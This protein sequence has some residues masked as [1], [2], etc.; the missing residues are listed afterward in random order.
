VQR[1]AR[2]VPQRLTQEVDDYRPTVTIYCAGKQEGELVFRGP[3]TRHW[4]EDLGTRHGHM[5]GIDDRLMEEGMAADYE[6]IAALTGRVTEIVKEARDIEVQAPSG[7]DLRAR[8]DPGR[9]RWVPCTGLIHEPG[10]WSNLPDGETFTSPLKLDGVLGGEVLGDHF[11][12]R[13]GVLSAPMLFEV[14]NSRIRRISF[15]DDE[16][17]QDVEGYMATHQN[18]NRAGEFAIGTNIGLAKLSGNLLQDEKIPGLHVAFGDPY[19]HET[20]ADW[21]APT[22]CD[23]VSTRATIKVDGQYLMRN[24]EFV[25]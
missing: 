18:S 10:T 20:G 6:Q 21:D 16:V 22:H 17:R 7:T 12:E 24:G 19:P 1:P 11:S 14:A 25:F 4:F 15:P 8:L 9:L 5:I 23:V 2:V 13:Y 3:L